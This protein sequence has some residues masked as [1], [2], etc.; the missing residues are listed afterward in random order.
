[1]LPGTLPAEVLAERL[2]ATDS[3]AVLK[4]GRTFTKVRDALATAGRLDEAWY[5]ERAT[6]G[7]QRLA[8]LAEVDSGQRCRTSRWP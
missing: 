2:A 6:T 3:A 4:L 7:E 1:M 5:V 8:P